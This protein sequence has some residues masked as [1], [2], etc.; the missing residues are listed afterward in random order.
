M[1]DKNSF[2]VYTDIK[3][4]VDELD[5]DQVATLFRT[6]LDYQIT[7]KVPKLTGSLKYI[8]IPI[9]QQMDRNN[10]K[11]QRTKEVRAESG[12]RGGLKSAETRFKQ[13]QANEANASFGSSNEA[14]EAKASKPSTV[15]ANEANEAVTV[16]VTDTVTVNGTVTDTVS[17]SVA[18][19]TASYLIGYL[20]EKTGSKYITD[21]TVK[22]RV[23]SLLAAGY[24][25]NQMRTVIDKKCAEWLGDPKMRQYLRPSTL[26]GEKFGEYLAA[27]IPLA[28]EREQKRAEDRA[29]LERTLN[30]KRRALSDLN[31]ALLVADKTERRLLRE[32]I[33]MLED[34]IGVIE[35][36]LA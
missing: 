13:K 32:N 3:E 36:R 2:V 10:E 30:E 19:E 6:M 24:T 16:T 8:F 28:A 23:G 25:L 27:P 31:E 29:T 14:N 11:W 4:V 12:R 17:A 26:F 5:N 21:G 15:E 7:G 33:A 9:R 34:S 35:R 20:N 18:D 22:E 1:D